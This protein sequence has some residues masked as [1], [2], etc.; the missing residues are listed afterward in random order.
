MNTSDPAAREL[1]A[2]NLCVSAGA[3]PLLQDLSLSCRP[4]EFLAI[5]GPNG[6]GKTT[7]LKALAGDLSRGPGAT[8]VV[9]G[10]VSIDGQ[11][12][13]SV[14]PRELAQRRVYLRQA[15]S[16]PFELSVLELVLLGA[17]AHNGG[18]ERRSDVALAW[19]ALEVTG[20]KEFARRSYPLLS[21]GEQQ[22][23]QLART[24][25]QLWGSPK[26]CRYLL[27]DE[28]TA[29]LDL[30]RAHDV[31]ALAWAQTRSGA[32][33]SHSGG[34]IGVVAVLHGLELAITYADRV[35][36]LKDG[37]LFAQGPPSSVL[38]E[39]TIQAVF[40]IQV[41][42]IDDPLT[43]RPLFV[44]ASHRPLRAA[45]LLRP[46]GANPLSSMELAHE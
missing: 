45:A 3:M 43:G 38:T 13:A 8:S 35:C 14:K 23:T 28:P 26:S 29:S 4:G 7:L 42:R 17:A 25:V 15:T 10:S 12:I 31:L 44:P 33:G 39:A 22:R 11:F 6:A 16:M 41:R 19:R 40:D 18:V 20:M 37:R 27:L 1:S 21:G 34:E 5:V 9:S 36:V 2:H 46:Q 24:L 30:A 32:N